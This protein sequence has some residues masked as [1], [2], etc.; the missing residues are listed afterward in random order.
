MTDETEQMVTDCEQRESQLSEWEAG[1]IDS[2]AH[3]LNHGR[4][5][6]AV[7]HAQL[8]VIWGRVTA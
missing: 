6:S 7:Q 8:V 5:L 3:Q 4:G 1:F 2:I